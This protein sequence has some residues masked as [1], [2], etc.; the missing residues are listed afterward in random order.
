VP[1]LGLLGLSVVEL[2]LG[3]RQTEGRTDRHCLSFYNAPD[4]RGITRHLL[5]SI[6]VRSGAVLR[7]HD[8]RALCRRLVTGCDDTHVNLG[9]LLCGIV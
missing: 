6:Q 7:R 9:G 4:L 3:T 5:A 2:D 1:I 8:G